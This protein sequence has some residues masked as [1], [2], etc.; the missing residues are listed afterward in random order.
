MI[1]VT[2]EQVADHV[3]WLDATEKSMQRTRMIA[4]DRYAEE[5]PAEYE[6]LRAEIARS[7]GLYWEITAL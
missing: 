5:H 3:A 6:Q 4:A 1:G 2:P 7:C